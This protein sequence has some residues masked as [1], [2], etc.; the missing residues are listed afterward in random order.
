MPLVDAQHVCLVENERYAAGKTLLEVP[1]G[2]IDPGESPEHDS[3][4]RACGRDRLSCGPDQPHPRMVRLAG[5]L[6]ERDVPLPLRGLGSPARPSLA[7]RAAAPV[8]V[9]WDG[10]RRHGT[11][12]P[13]RRRQ[14]DP[15]DLGLRSAQKT[16]SFRI[17]QALGTREK[18]LPLVLAS[19]RFGIQG[20]VFVPDRSA[21]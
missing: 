1:A 14:V 4:A 6:T 19:A 20:K 5:F 16:M 21:W 11:G 18:C 13:D 12:R 15:R 7:R 8:V 3:R 2:T 9:R 10:C 17:T